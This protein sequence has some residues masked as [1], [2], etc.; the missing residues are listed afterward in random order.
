MTLNEPVWTQIW[1]CDN[2]ERVYCALKM[3]PTTRTLHIIE[4]A[5]MTV[6]SKS[7][8][9][10]PLSLLIFQENQ[11]EEISTKRKSQA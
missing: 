5:F 3:I 1:S 8:P 6:L 4:S 9:K 2:G 7:P 10:C 11:N